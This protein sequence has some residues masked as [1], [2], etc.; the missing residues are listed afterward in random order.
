MPLPDP[1]SSDGEPDSADDK[2]EWDDSQP[3]PEHHHDKRPRPATASTPR[4]FRPARARCK[5]PK[6]QRPCFNIQHEVHLAD[7]FQPEQLRPAVPNHWSHAE[8]PPPLSRP[9]KARYALTDWELKRGCGS[10]FDR[11]ER[12]FTS[13][14]G[15]EASILDFFDKSRA[16][17]E[18][19]GLATPYKGVWA[20]GDDDDDNAAEDDSVMDPNDLRTDGVRPVTLK[21]RDFGSL[22]LDFVGGIWLETRY[23]LFKIEGP[24]YPSSRTGSSL[25]ALV[26]LYGV[27]SANQVRGQHLATESAGERYIRLAMAELDW[28]SLGNWDEFMPSWVEM[29]P[30]EAHAWLGSDRLCRALYRVLPNTPWFLPEV[31]ALVEGRVYRHLYRASPDYDPNAILAERELDANRWATLRAAVVEWHGQAFK[32]AVEYTKTRDYSKLWRSLPHKTV[33]SDAEERDGDGDEPTESWYECAVLDEDIEVEVEV[34]AGQ[35]ENITRGT[36]V[37]IAGSALDSLDETATSE[38]WIG[39]VEMLF[40]VLRPSPQKELMAHISWMTSQAD[41]PFGPAWPGRLLCRQSGACVDYALSSVVIKTVDVREL[42][43]GERLPPAGEEPETFYTRGTVADLATASFVHEQDIIDELP[44]N[45]SDIMSDLANGHR[46]QQPDVCLSCCQKANARWNQSGPHRAEHGFNWQGVDYHN[47]DLVYL[48]PA[49]Y[50]AKSKE[51]KVELDEAGEALEGAGA[52]YP[53]PFALARLVLLADNVALRP[54]S[55]LQV[56]LVFRADDVLPDPIGFKCERQ[57]VVL[58]GQSFQ[59]KVS[60]LLGRATLEHWNSLVKAYMGSPEWTDHKQRAITL[61]RLNADLSPDSFFVRQQLIWDRMSARAQEIITKQP[62]LD[63]RQLAKLG[64]GQATKKLQATTLDWCA[65]CAD[66]VRTARAASEKA[67]ELGQAE[68]KRSFAFEAY[69]GAG[70]LSSSLHAAN[71]L[72]A[73]KFHCDKEADI[74]A[75]YGHTNPGSVAFA[76]TMSDLVERAAL[77]QS[78]G[79]PLPVSPVKVHT[80]AGGAP[81]QGYS[82]CSRF[83]SSTDSRTIEPFVLLSAIL[84][85]RVSRSRS[86]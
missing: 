15:K 82:L 59:V 55:L 21:S 70:G 35:L 10:K 28:S 81:C 46:H 42:G 23:S 77:A 72:S 12:T 74:A 63:P 60:D 73:L 51:V 80:V 1:N 34:A 16:G 20:V 54:D 36:Y 25:R 17:L 84:L 44:A 11:M 2:P 45:I 14:G 9:Q 66:N 61:A 27:A 68:E 62:R 39:K 75:A 8:V 13:F 86:P 49:G 19:A 41:L 48:K 53:A 83:R 64:I 29:A 40:K 31:A 58:T 26:T 3:R 76:E 78:S 43:L 4:T 56:Q 7:F 65:H 18:L 69:S 24:L 38:P 67:R 32:P 47:D 85:W 50:G 5:L 22:K 79:Q 71:P 52:D 30:I 37:L 6:N 57:V 33:N